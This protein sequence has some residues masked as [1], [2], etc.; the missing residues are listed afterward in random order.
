VATLPEGWV[1]VIPHAD[2]TRVG[3]PLHRDGAIAHQQALAALRA[4]RLHNRLVAAHCP[5]GAS[6]PRSRYL[7]TPSTDPDSPW[8]VEAGSV[9]VLPAPLERSLAQQRRRTFWNV[10]LAIPD[11][12]IEALPEKLLPGDCQGRWRLRWWHRL[13]WHSLR[14]ILMAPV[15]IVALGRRWMRP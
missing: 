15:W 4:S 14:R 11:P 10:F 13:Y 5:W 6:R 7:R 12:A 1:E 9:P 3:V 8:R 2:A